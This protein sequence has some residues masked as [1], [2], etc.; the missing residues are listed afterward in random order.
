MTAFH[1][2]HAAHEKQTADSEII[3]NLRHLQR[4]SKVVRQISGLHAP[5]VQGRQ[6]VAVKAVPDHRLRARNPFVKLGV[7]RADAQFPGCN[8]VHHDLP[9]PGHD[10]EIGIKGKNLPIQHIIREIRPVGGNM[11]QLF[12][13][14]DRPEPVGPHRLVP[15]NVH[16][17]R[18][19]DKSNQFAHLVLPIRHGRHIR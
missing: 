18:D 1:F 13:R 16:V 14:L 2:G 6:P 4:M 5:P 17:S 8:Q 10:I 3:E 7:E 12:Q 15:L 9:V 11:L 19:N